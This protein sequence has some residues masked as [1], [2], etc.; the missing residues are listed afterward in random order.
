MNTTTA[1]EPQMNTDEHGWVVKVLGF[2]FVAVMAGSAAAATP[3]PSAKWSFVFK[4][5]KGQPD[6]PIRVYT[7]RPRLCDTTCPIVILLPG[8]KRDASSY[9]D[10]WELAADR[11]KFMLVAPEFN[12]AFWPKAASY[13]LGDVANQP[14]RQKWAYAAIEHLFDE[15]RDG[16]AGYVLFGHA[17]GA[18]FAQRMALLVPEHRATTIIVANPGW[19][20]LP[21]WRKEKTTHPYPYSLVSSPAGEAEARKA[22]PRRLVLM[23]SE[24]DI[25]PDDEKS[26]DSDGAVKQGDTRVD[27]AETFIKTATTAANDLGVKLAWELVEL[28]DAQQTGE[29]LSRLAA[30]A[31]YGKK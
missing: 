13:N 15:V 24:K 11:W 29:G 7:Y 10:Y 5:A 28:P 3:I 27:R 26:V 2:L 31:L 17:G 4:D 14:D 8:S 23:V 18:Q 22:L 25:D 30:E 19:Y 1:G 16:Q 6:R 12:V 20:L 9:R 21:E